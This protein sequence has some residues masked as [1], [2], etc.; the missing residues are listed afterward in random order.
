MVTKWKVAIS[1]FLR[2]SAETKAPFDQPFPFRESR[3]IQKRNPKISQGNSVPGRLMK[4]AT[5]I[6]HLM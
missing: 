2:K 5:V 4:Q 6:V 3:K 1:L